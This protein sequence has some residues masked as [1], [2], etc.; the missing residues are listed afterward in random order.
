MK[1]DLDTVLTY[2][3]LIGSAFLLALLLGL[4]TGL[5][6]VVACSVVLLAGKL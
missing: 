3:A 5:A 6:S 4:P 1:R 2:P